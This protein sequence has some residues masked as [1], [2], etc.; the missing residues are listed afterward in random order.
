MGL[1]VGLK[2]WQYLPNKH[3]GAMPIFRIP[4]KR[5]VTEEPSRSASNDLRLSLVERPSKSLDSDCPHWLEEQPPFDGLEVPHWF[6]GA[7]GKPKP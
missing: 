2:G 5:H 6:D 7:V 3:E 4:T 1:V